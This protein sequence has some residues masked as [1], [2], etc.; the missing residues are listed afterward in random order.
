[1][2]KN[3]SLNEL[4]LIAEDIV[5]NAQ[6]KV[7]LFYGDMGVGKTTLIK[8]ICKVLGV[9]DAAHSPTFS[10]VNEYQTTN[11]DIVYHFDFYRIEH[12]EE[13]YD[14]GVEDYLYSNNWCLIE[15]PEN[16]KNLL[17]LDAVT[18]KINLLENGQRNIQLTN[19]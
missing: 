8:E 2:N 16:V 19:N 9:E 6:N 1:M 10:L 4:T 14:M 7:L 13:A 15:W 18:V 12:E 3:Y 5:K 17:P 11:S